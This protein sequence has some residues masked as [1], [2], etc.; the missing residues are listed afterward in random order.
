ME[1]SGDGNRNSSRH[2]S[3]T[4]VEDRRVPTSGSVRTVPGQSHFIFP[5]HKCGRQERRDR[6]EGVSSRRV[7]NR[8]TGVLERCLNASGTGE[9]PR[10]PFVS[11]DKGSR[12][13]GEETGS[14]TT[15][16]HKSRDSGRESMA[17]VR[18]LWA[19][20]TPTKEH[21][22]LLGGNGFGAR[23]STDNRRRNPGC[24]DSL[25]TLT[26]GKELGPLLVST[27]SAFLLPVKVELTRHW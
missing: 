11:R 1:T 15:E 22:D 23:G 24:T 21:L 25:E 4:L 2:V 8:D 3:A 14:G 5:T 17:H 6:E 18:P 16:R 12:T 9:R 13:P 20:T 7:T 19:R 10:S 27:S 26:Q